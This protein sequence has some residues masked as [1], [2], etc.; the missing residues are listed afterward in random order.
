MTA[1]VTDLY[2][3]SAPDTPGEPLN[4]EF[5]VWAR[6]AAVLLSGHPYRYAPS[7]VRSL[8]GELMF[9]VADEMERMAATRERWERV[10]TWAERRDA[11][12]GR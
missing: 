5:P 9:P 12:A 3:P 6:K 1:T 8:F 2:P 11:G 4:P 10:A 7:R